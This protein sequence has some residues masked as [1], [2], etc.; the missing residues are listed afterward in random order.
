[1]IK[2]FK[3]LFYLSIFFMVVL[4]GACDFTKNNNVTNPRAMFMGDS[5]F[6]LSGDISERI[7]EL[8]G[9]VYR[10]YSVSGAK[11]DDIIGQY[12][13]AKGEDSDIRTVIMDGGGNDIKDESV[14][15]NDV[16]NANCQNMIDDIAVLVDD[17]LTEMH[18]DG[19]QN[20][21]YMGYYHLFAKNEGLNPAVDYASE[22]AIDVCADAALNC[23]FVDTRPSFEG[24]PE[25]VL[26]DDLHP[27]REGSNVIGDLI[28]DTMVANDIEQ[29]L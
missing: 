14:C 8:S 20:V 17:M 1:M 10:E 28:W 2:R 23:Y 26:S 25:Y 29:N 11:I 9:E 24:H 22:M 5:I 12:D 21:V 13:K 16:L 3:F 6:D 19:V 15:H 27:T 18:T 7:E 4:L